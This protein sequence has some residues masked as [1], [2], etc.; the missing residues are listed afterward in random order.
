MTALPIGTKLNVNTASEALLASLSDNLDSSTA[1]SLIEERGQAEFVDIDATFEGLVEPE[2]LQRIDGVTEHF[3]L[4]ATVTL[5]TNQLTMRSVLQ[6]DRERRHASAVPQSRSRVTDGRLLVH[7]ARRRR[8]AC[9]V[10]RGSMPTG[11]C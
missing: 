4:T 5:G 8:I 10:G 11:G 7:R 9:D 6:R 3:L 1:A 2:T